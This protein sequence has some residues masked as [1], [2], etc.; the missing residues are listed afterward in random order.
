MRAG[1]TEV[2]NTRNAARKRHLAN[3]AQTTSG[4][5]RRR[6]LANNYE[7]PSGR[8]VIAC[9]RPHYASCPS[10]C[11]SVC[12]SIRPVRARNSK[13]K[14]TLKRRDAAVAMRC[15]EN[16]VTPYFAAQP[17][18][19]INAFSMG[20]CFVKYMTHN[21]SATTQDGGTVTKDHL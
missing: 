17:Q 9:V 16:I 18:N 11:P 12:S 6:H 4:R 10:V 3:G 8:R 7:T 1:L 13:T 5:R 2:R 14:K 19:G 15:G 20:I 21:I